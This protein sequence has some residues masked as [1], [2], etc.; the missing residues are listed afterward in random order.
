MTMLTSN[1]ATRPKATLDRI[2]EGSVDL[3]KGVSISAILGEDGRIAIIQ[4]S[5]PT[6][7]GGI[8]TKGIPIHK[9][10]MSK[11]GLKWLTSRSGTWELKIEEDRSL[12][13]YPSVWCVGHDVHGLIRDGAWKSFHFELSDLPQTEAERRIDRAIKQAEE[14]GGDYWG[15]ILALAEKSYF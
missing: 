6:K 7:D 9:G 2:R 8:C 1:T 13:L 11:R 3:G 15:A 12:S 14:Y 10:K 4:F 5:H